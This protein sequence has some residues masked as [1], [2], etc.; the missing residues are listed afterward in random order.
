MPFGKDKVATDLCKRKGFRGEH[1]FDAYDSRWL[2]ASSHLRERDKVLLRAILIGS[3]RPKMR[4]S[5]VGSAMLLK[6][7][8]TFS[9]IVFFTLLWNPNRPEFIPLVNR[10]R[11]K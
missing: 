1:C 5:D 11:T 10:D 4:T 8:V 6:L 3:A 9:G 7:I 2:L